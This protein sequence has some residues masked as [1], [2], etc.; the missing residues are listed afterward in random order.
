[1]AGDNHYLKGLAV[2]YAKGWDTL[3]KFSNVFYVCDSANHHIPE[4]QGICKE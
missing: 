1:M 2:G 4:K 3:I